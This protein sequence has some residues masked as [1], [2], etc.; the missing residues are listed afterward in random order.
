LREH[1]A[2]PVLLSADGGGVEDTG[3]PLEH[4][5]VSQSSLNL[6]WKEIKMNR[7]KIKFFWTNLMNIALDCEDLP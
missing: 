5:D 3:G 6:E 2:F 1:A 4:E 7:K